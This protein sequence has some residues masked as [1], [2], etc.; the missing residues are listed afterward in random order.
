[1]IA[2]AWHKYRAQLD[3]VEELFYLVVLATEACMIYPWQ[4]LISSLFGYQGLSLWGVCLLLWV[5]YFVV[6][7]INRTELPLDRKQA[8][9]AGL[10]IAGALVAV[11]FQTYSGRPLWDVAWIGEMADRFF[12]VFARIPPDLGAVILAFVGWWRG[13]VAARQDYDN[14]D[15]WFHFRLGVV[16]LF[17]YS[18]QLLTFSLVARHDNLVAVPEAIVFAYRKQRHLIHTRL[19]GMLEV[20]TQPDREVLVGKQTATGWGRISLPRN[21]ALKSAMPESR[22]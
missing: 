3:W 5:P 8:L 15:A 18:L 17:G 12:S 7:L 13:I 21:W 16:I 10:M 14:Q 20:I 19:T 4:L 1:M 6:S 11:R 2:E 22:P 9:V